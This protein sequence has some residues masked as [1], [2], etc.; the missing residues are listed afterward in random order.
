[1]GRLDASALAFHRRM[2]PSMNLEARRDGHVDS[3]GAELRTWH[4][5]KRERELSKPKFLVFS[6]VAGCSRIKLSVE[7]SAVWNSG[8]E[9]PK[10]PLYNDSLIATEYLLRARHWG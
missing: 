2:T 7:I 3:Y 4:I 9:E 6:F 8:C 1:M 5:T 10:S